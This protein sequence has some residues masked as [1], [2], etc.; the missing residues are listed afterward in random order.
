VE[1]ISYKKFVI[2]EM[3]DSFISWRF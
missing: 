1:V 3:R 2:Y